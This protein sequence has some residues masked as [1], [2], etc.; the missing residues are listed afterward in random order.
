MPMCSNLQKCK[1][2]KSSR[3][4]FY[5]KERYAVWRVMEYG[6]ISGVDQMKA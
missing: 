5:P 4:G 1:D 6:S 2:F 3:G